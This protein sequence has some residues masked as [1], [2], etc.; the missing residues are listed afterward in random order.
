MKKN[1]KWAE[2]ENISERRENLL[3]I[4]VCVNLYNC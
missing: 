3:Y 4:V 1:R 2:E